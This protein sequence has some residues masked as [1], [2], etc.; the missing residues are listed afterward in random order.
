MCSP[1]P[2]S[3]GLG[4]WCKIL[5]RLQIRTMQQGQGWK[6]GGTKAVVGVEKFWGRVGYCREC[7]TETVHQFW[8][9]PSILKLPS[10]AVMYWH[11][12][13]K[14]TVQDKGFWQPHMYI[15]YCTMWGFI[16]WLQWQKSSI[17]HFHA[18]SKRDLV[19]CFLH[20]EMI[21]KQELSQHYYSN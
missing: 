17:S 20:T 1:L 14:H 18:L 13:K 2:R 11:V 16:M 21:K 7:L 9:K 15:K 10:P 4:G 6:P 5:G 8:P 3:P 19:L 12:T